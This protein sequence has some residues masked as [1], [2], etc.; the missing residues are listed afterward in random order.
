MCSLRSQS[1]LTVHSTDPYNAE[2]APERLVSSFLTPQKDLYVRSHGPVPMLDAGHHRLTVDGLVATP[3][4]LSM[5]EIRRRFPVR[6]VTSVL[7]CAGNRRGDL[8]QVRPVSGD[9]WSAGAVGNAVWTGAALADVLHAAGVAADANPSMHIVFTACDTCETDHERYRY[10]ASIPIGKAL[11]PE[12]L[13]AYAINGEDLAAEHG[14]PL[15]V[16]VPGYAGVRSVKWVTGITVQL[17]PSDARPQARDY[18]LF[19]PHVTKETADWDAGMTINE[20][21]VNAA[22]CQP[23]AGARLQPGPTLLRGYA[24]VSGRAVVRVDVSADGGRSWHQ[25]MLKCDQAAPWGW[26]LWEA[27]TDLPPGEHDLVVRA[28]D[29]AGQTQPSS[30]DD[31]WNFKGYLNNAWHRI[32]VTAG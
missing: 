3:L 12:V 5:V 30:P 26:T 18:K 9:P 7:Q 10:A 19:P 28:W 4:D 14:F 17:E 32:R 11:S 6:S 13:L 24:T 2:P 8:R 29:S 20:M 22:I 1:S 15:R 16:V 27:T 23:S 21:P 31:T 25:G